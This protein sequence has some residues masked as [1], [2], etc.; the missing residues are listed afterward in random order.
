[1]IKR[2]FRPFWKY[3]VVATENWLAGMAG[4]GFLLQSIDYRRRLFIFKEGEPQKLIYR[5]DYSKEEK[6][7]TP[8]LK[9]EGWREISSRRGWF[10]L[11]NANPNPPVIDDCS[12][13]SI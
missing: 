13:H 5:I 12:L 3:N 9:K 7:I 1:M 6:E 2:A 10:I 8:T 11:T 4:A